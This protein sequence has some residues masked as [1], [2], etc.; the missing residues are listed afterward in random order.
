MGGQPWRD[1]HNKPKTVVEALVVKTKKKIK[2]KK[3]RKKE[4]RKGIKDRKW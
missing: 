3:M 1:V 4:R 2:N